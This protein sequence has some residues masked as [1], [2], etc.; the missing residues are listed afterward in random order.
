MTQQSTAL[1]NPRIPGHRHDEDGLIPLL[2]HPPAAESA[3]RAQRNA[4]RILVVEGEPNAAMSLVQ[5]L[6]RH[7]YQAESVA[8]GAKALQAHHNCDLVLLD[9]ELPDLDGLEICRSIRAICDTPIIVVTARDTELDRVLGL[10]AGSDDYLAK[11]YGFRELMARIEAVMR[12]A[13]PQRPLPQVITRG[14]LRI[15]AGTREIRLGGRLIEVTR[16]EFDLLH[17]LAS[18]PETVI[19]RRQLMVQ[20]WDDSWSRPGRT[21]DTHVSSLR[22]KL[23]SSSWIVTVRGVGFRLG[24]A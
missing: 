3:V 7:G 15:D 1:L 19:S 22:N 4:L 14:L 20:V 23:G 21:L 24:H 8:T 16:K 18:Q 13:R 9:L 11:P 17:L 2:T 5:L 10:Q 6:R 12:R